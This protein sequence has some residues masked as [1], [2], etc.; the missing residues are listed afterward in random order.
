M[1]R[2]C[3]VGR[4]TFCGY[5]DLS[6]FCDAVKITACK[7]SAV[8]LRYHR[9]AHSHQLLLV[10]YWADGNMTLRSN[11]LALFT[12]LKHDCPDICVIHDSTYA[13]HV[14]RRC[15]QSS[16]RRVSSSQRRTRGAAIILDTWTVYCWILKHERQRTET[17][18]THTAHTV[19]IY[20]VLCITPP[21]I[22][23]L[24]FSPPSH[25]THCHYFHQHVPSRR[26]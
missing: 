21:R 26:Q 1:D 22:V 10:E 7:E 17:A 16:L 11:T 14:R 24:T 6:C 15:L 8:L 13:V 18:H 3:L 9:G 4:V 20:V 25:L 12:P 5:I 2:I 23:S 19:I